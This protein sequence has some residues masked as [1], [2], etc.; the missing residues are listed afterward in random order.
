M[1]TAELFEPLPLRRGPAM[2]NRFMLAPLT[3]QQSAPDGRAT[4]DDVEWMKR[5]ARG[6]YALVQTCATTVE[7]GGRAFRGQLGI[8]DDDLAPEL[9]RMADAIRAGGALSAVQIHHAGHR[10]RPELGG[11]PA[12]ASEGNAPGYAAL[13]LDEVERIRDSFVHAARR[14]ERAGFDGVAVHGAFGWILSEFLSPLLNRR[15]D[16]YGGSLENRARLIFEVI[17]GIRAACRPD[18]QIGLRLSVE[19][20]GLRF[21]ELV[22]VAAEVMHQQKI[23]YFD[24]ALWDSRQA[25]PEGSY[26]DRSMLSAFTGLPRH[27]VRL[28]VAGKIRDVARCAELLQEGCDFVLIARA[29]ILCPD[30]PLRARANPAYVSPTLPVSAAHLREMGLSLPFID[31]MRTAW[32]GFVARE[33]AEH[34]PTKTDDQPRI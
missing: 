18:F 22:D 21:E 6:G 8:H 3:N 33:D 25:A 17:D 13:N 15:T 31:Y 30:F 29:A 32:D 11:V 5:V 26:R 20:Y 10:A 1:R 23:D 34:C 19:R 14:A 28:G 27:G 16:R 9:S 2:K 7:A 4:D 24:L 12:P